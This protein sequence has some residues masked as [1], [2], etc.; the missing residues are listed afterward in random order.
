MSLAYNCNFTPMALEFTLFNQCSLE[1]NSTLSSPGFTLHPTCIKPALLQQIPHPSQLAIG[2]LAP[3]TLWNFGKLN[4]L[5]IWT[6][7]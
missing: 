5:D 1:S 3:I 4:F 2:H 6:T 7:L